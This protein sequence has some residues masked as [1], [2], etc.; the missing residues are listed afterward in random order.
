MQRWNLI[1]E[2]HLEFLSLFL[3]SWRAERE[4]KATIKWKSF[5]SH[6]FEKVFPWEL[7]RENNIRKASPVF[8]TFPICLF[9][10]I[11]HKTE[12]FYSSY[13]FLESYPFKYMKAATKPRGMLSKL[14][15]QLG[16]LFLLVLFLKILLFHLK[17]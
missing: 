6:S 5:F 13:H 9:S 17:M 8:L 16:L 2:I 3:R 7:R 15:S 10:I 4:G 1:I 12:H 14:G 11:H